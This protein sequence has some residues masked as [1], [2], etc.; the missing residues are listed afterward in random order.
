MANECQHWK[1][2]T[3]DT[4][5][6]AM[7]RTVQGSMDMAAGEWPTRPGQQSLAHSI[8]LGWIGTAMVMVLATAKPD[9]LCRIDAGVKTV[10]CTEVLSVNPSPQRME[11]SEASKEELAPARGER[12]ST[13]TRDQ[14]HWMHAAFC[15]NQPTR[16]GR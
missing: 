4:T 5:E 1:Q 15:Y 8:S 10:L 16:Q 13:W 3:W 11:P 9:D 2:E 14:Q 12:K 7:L 6:Q